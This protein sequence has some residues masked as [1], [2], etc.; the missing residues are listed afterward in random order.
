MPPATEQLEAD[1]LAIQQAMQRWDREHP[2]LNQSWWMKHPAPVVLLC[3]LPMILATFVADFGENGWM[4][5]VVMEITLAICCAAPL[6]MPAGKLQRAAWRNLYYGELVIAWSLSFL[7]ANAVH[8]V[9]GAG[10]VAGWPVFFIMLILGGCFSKINQRRSPLTMSSQVD[11]KA[12]AQFTRQIAGVT[13]D[14]ADIDATHSIP[15][16]HI[17]DTLVTHDRS[18]SDN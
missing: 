8:D 5:A 16:T 6:F 12:I 14:T 7:L 13:N 4:L 9:P 1:S 18:C 11:Y 10:F 15:R 2:S 17:S 3:L